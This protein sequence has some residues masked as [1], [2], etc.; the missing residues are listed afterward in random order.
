MAEQVQIEVPQG[1]LTQNVLSLTNHYEG[2][3]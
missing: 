1:P 2:Q 3:A